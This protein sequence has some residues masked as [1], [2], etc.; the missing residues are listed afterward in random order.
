MVRREELC[1]GPQLCNDHPTTHAD[2]C[3]MVLL[4][5]AFDGWRGQVIRR[6]SDLRFAAEAGVRIGLD[7]IQMD[8]FIAM[9]LIS[10]ELNQQTEEKM[11]AGSRQRQ[12]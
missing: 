5:R 8:E 2:E 6:A 3:P 7:E 11:R 10:A 4:D 12:P 1:G 9:R